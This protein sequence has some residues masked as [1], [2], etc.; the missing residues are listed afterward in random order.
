MI[1]LIVESLPW[2]VDRWQTCPVLRGDEGCPAYRFHFALL[3]HYVV[4]RRLQRPAIHLTHILIKHSILHGHP[5]SLGLRK[6][7]HRQGTIICIREATIP[8]ELRGI[9]RELL[10]LPKVII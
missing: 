3:A 2:R 4:Y 6:L 7:S 9:L 8:L 10:D 1:R 5:R